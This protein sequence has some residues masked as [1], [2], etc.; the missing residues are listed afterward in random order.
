MIIKHEYKYNYF[1]KITNLLNGNFYYGIHSTNDLED[2]YMGSGLKLKRAFK[3]YGIENFSKEIIKFFDTRKELSDYEATVVT[4]EL[5]SDNNCYNIS[6]GGEQLSVCGTFTAYNKEKEIWERIT[7]VEYEN[8]K[9]N[10]LKAPC[11]NKVSVKYKNDNS[12]NFFYIDKNEYDNHKELYDLP[13]SYKKHTLVVKYKDN[14]NKAVIINKED[15]DE[16]KY[17]KV[18]LNKGEFFVR[19][20]SGKVF[21]TSN[22]DP[23]YLSG[24]LVTA[25]TG[26]K[27]SDEQKNKLKKK[28]AESNHQKGKYNSQYGTKWIYKDSVCKKVKINELEKYLQDGWN[29]GNLNTRKIK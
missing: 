20:K 3:K 9:D 14:P 13:F 17:I 27:W 12:N 21:K 23:R 15:F 7:Y 4:E 8:N 26:Y 16:T 5:V 28:F 11:I 24:E 18:C 10:Y 22:N 19:D 2:G 6:L 1:Y 29:L 25:C